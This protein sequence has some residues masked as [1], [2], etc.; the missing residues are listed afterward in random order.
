MWIAPCMVYSEACTYNVVGTN[1]TTHVTLDHPC[2]DL[3]L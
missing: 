1:A 2:H 3:F